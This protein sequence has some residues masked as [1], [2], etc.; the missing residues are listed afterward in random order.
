MKIQIFGKLAP[1]ALLA[2]RVSLLI[3]LIR[4]K[5]RKP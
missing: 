3:E 5:R 4:P 2:Q 1:T